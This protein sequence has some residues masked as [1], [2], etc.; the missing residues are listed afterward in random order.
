MDN[1]DRCGKSLCSPGDHIV[2]M[3][4]DVDDSIIVRNDLCSACTKELKK[5]NRE[6]NKL[7]KIG[8]IKVIVEN[9]FY[10][11]EDLIR[12]V[13]PEVFVHLDGSKQRLLKELREEL[14]E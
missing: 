10:T 13:C 12:G 2:E 14:G 1:C 5:M 11:I 7:K 8:R 6:I 3:T 9:T 4:Y